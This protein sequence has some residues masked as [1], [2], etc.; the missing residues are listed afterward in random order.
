MI[1][2]KPPP[3]MRH[4]YLLFLDYDSYWFTPVN[5]GTAFTC[6]PEPGITVRGIP[7]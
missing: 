7:N 6:I 5:G 4:E 3:T 1:N 2:L